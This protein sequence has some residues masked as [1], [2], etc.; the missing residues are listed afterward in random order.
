M[1]LSESVNRVRAHS[2]SSSLMFEAVEQAIEGGFPFLGR[3]V[4]AGGDLAA[5]AFDQ[6]RSNV[7]AVVPAGAALA[8]GSACHALAFLVS[9]GGRCSVDGGFRRGARALPPGGG[10]ALGTRQI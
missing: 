10:P 7:F 4:G 3:V 2:Y 1:R 9:L 5:N 6:L 8:A